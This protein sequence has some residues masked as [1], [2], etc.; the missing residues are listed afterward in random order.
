MMEGYSKVKK[1]NSYKSEVGNISRMDYSKTY[2]NRPF[3]LKGVLSN[4]QSVGNLGASKKN[5]G[6]SFYEEG[7]LPPIMSPRDRYNAAQDE[8]TT[9]EFVLDQSEIPAKKHE[10][11][12]IKQGDITDLINLSPRDILNDTNSNTN[13]QNLSQMSILPKYISKKSRNKSMF[14]QLSLPGL[15]KSSTINPA[16]SHIISPRDNRED[17]PSQTISNFNKQILASMNWGQDSGDIR[18]VKIPR[19]PS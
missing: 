13:S 16:I 5:Q 3:E 11:T 9:Q 10:D 1:G 19:R 6:I 4:S 18:P 2:S 17:S 8:D 12:I 7:S 15:K 14:K